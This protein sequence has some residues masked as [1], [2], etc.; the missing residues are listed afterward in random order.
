MRSLLRRATAGQQVGI[1]VI[2]V[3]LLVVSEILN[4]TTL[5]FTNIIEIL[6]STAVYFI[7]ACGATLLLVGGGLDL[8]VGSLFAVGGVAAGLLMNAG[9]AW[10]LA[11]ILAVAITG[12]FGAVNAFVILR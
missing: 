5:H 9:V 2:L 1:V 7:A 8:S 6:R 10:P 4:P 11:V 3:L 12:L